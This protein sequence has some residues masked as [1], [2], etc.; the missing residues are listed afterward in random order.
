MQIVLDN[1]IEGIPESKKI[2][3][4]TLDF[5]LHNLEKQKENLIS[6]FVGD[7]NIIRKNEPS[8]EI[9]DA[10]IAVDWFIKKWEKRAK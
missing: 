3:Y 1:F 4:V 8:D 10:T 7:L 9:T 6:E 5:Y 2:D